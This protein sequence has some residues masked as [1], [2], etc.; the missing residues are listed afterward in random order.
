MKNPETLLRQQSQKR[1]KKSSD[2]GEQS[3]G[4]KSSKISKK[5][6][7]S[8]LPPLQQTNTRNMS[9]LS[10]GRLKSGHTD[11]ARDTYGQGFR[12]TAQLPKVFRDDVLPIE[13]LVQ[14]TER[15]AHMFEEDGFGVRR[16]RL[17]KQEFQGFLHDV[18]ALVADEETA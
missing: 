16:Y 14:K 15:E 1:F 12:T 18:Q 8:V 13:Q 3:S 2:D 10:K 6:S 11:A 17:P 9:T 7:S 5:D 4:H